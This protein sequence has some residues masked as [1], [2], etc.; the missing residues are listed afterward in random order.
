MHISGFTFLIEKDGLINQVSIGGQIQKI[1]DL[2]QWRNEIRIVEV[3]LF[4]DYP[5]LIVSYGTHPCSYVFI[6]SDHIYGG[7]KAWDIPVDCHGGVTLTQPA[8]V[9]IPD[10]V[11]KMSNPYVEYGS[12]FSIIEQDSFVIGW[13]YAHGDDFYLER[14][15]W[16][17]K[18][19]TL[20]E[21]RCECQ[22]VIEQLDF[23]MNP[24]QRIYV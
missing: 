4:K 16:G 14:K 6:N 21:L 3:G 20:A 12:F 7:E 11:N 24:Q 2:Y 17:T 13:D 1:S 18:V 8:N 15:H 10:I 22:D 5:Y 9:F 19:W 23:I